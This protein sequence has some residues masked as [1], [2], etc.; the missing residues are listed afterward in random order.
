MTEELKVNVPDTTQ[1]IQGIVAWASIAY[2]AGFLTILVH[3]ARLGIPVL[4]VLKPI[5]IWVGAPFAL[6]LFY[7][8]WLWS[9]IQ[10]RREELNRDL[11][12]LKEELRRPEKMQDIEWLR[13][14]LRLVAHHSP[15]VLNVAGRKQRE[16]LTRLADRLSERIPAS[17]YIT[18][19]AKSRMTVILRGAFAMLLL[20]RFAMFL[21]HLAFIPLVLYLYAWF[22]YPEVPQRLGGGRAVAVRLV[23]NSEKIPLDVDELRTLFPVAGARGGEAATKARTT[24]PVD[25]LYSTKESYYVRCGAQPVVSIRAEAVQGIIWIGASGARSCEVAPAIVKP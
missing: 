14:V 2:A 12:S 11:A 23:L 3:T 18:G 6:A 5:N 22:I 10:R 25:L 1:Y 24:L 15:L 8:R 4:E 7:A 13:R 9:L 19:K 16:L 20:Y 21:I 17:E